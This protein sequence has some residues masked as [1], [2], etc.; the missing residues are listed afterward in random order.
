MGR[1]AVSGPDAKRLADCLGLAVEDYDAGKVGA[2]LVVIA[3]NDSTLG[4]DDLR[5]A[6]KKG[7]KVLVVGNDEIA[8]EAGFTFTKFFET[9]IRWAQKKME[10]ADD[11]M[12]DFKRPKNQACRLSAM[13]TLT[14][15]M[16]AVAAVAA[17]LGQRP[18]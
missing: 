1:V 18:R 11:H 17:A 15:A 2:G 8:K 3:G 4:L 14:C 5:A 12:K 7:A 13:A 10:Y 9:Q 16:A 6:V